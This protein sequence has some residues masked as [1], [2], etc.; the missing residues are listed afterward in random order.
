MGFSGLVGVP[1]GGQGGAAGG[2]T[3]D[4]CSSILATVGAAPA[5]AATQGV[6]RG[7][8]NDVGLMLGKKI[9]LN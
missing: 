5:R 3:S 9:K 7:D 2:A 1:K 8:Q 4:Q 6:A